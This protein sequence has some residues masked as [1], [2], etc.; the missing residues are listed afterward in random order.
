MNKQ[1]KEDLIQALYDIGGCDAEDEW[2][3]GYDDG[4]NAAIEVVKEIKVQEKAIVPKFVAY[5]FEDNFEEL[6]WEL[7]GVLINAFNTNRSERSDFQDWLVD[8]TNYPIETLIRM[9][10]F[11]Y[12]VEKEQLYYV[13]FGFDR[14]LIKGDCKTT[15]GEDFIWIEVWECIEN[16]GFEELVKFTEQEIKAID[17]RYW[18]F[19]VK[20]GEE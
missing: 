10:L 8:T 1:E 18:P 20:V 16:E 13:S 6:D 12:E 19:A 4:V 11:G 2:S 14:F 5:W 9:K 7:G 15:T 3:R 17:E